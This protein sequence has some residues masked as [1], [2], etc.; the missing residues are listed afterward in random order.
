MWAD[1]G[2]N[3]VR[4]VSPVSAQHLGAAGLCEVSA[5]R[6]SHPTYQQHVRCSAA[7]TKEGASRSQRQMV[8]RLHFAHKFALDAT[9]KRCVRCVRGQ[10]DHVGQDSAVRCQDICSHEGGATVR[11]GA[12]RDLGGRLYK[13][14]S[15]LDGFYSFRYVFII[16]HIRSAPLLTFF[17]Y[18]ASAPAEPPKP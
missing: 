4:D 1:S 13:A 18:V 3:D 11:L 12:L 2:S 15:S 14:S 16:D 10:G 7:T 5:E 6:I 8:C 9:L 17:L